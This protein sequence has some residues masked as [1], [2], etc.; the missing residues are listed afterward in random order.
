M[1]I[2][3][4]HHYRFYTKKR[5]PD[6]LSEWL[7]W[8][9]DYLINNQDP[10]TFMTLAWSIDE[11]ETIS[12][13]NLEVIRSYKWFYL[14]SK[15]CKSSSDRQ[16]SRSEMHICKKRFLADKEI[17]QIIINAKNWENLIGTRKK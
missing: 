8:L 7:F 17:N 13:D 5:N 4:F 3:I 16:R 9:E 1:V 14:C 12:V 2:M 6:D 10:D 15:F 11:D